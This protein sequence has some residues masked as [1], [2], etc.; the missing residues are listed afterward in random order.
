MTPRSLKHSY[1]IVLVI[2]ALL[3]VGAGLLWSSDVDEDLREGLPE[4]TMGEG[5][6]TSVTCRACHPAQYDAWHRSYHRTMTQ[7]ATPSTVLGMFDDIVLECGVGVHI[8]TQ[9]NL[10]VG[11]PDLSTPEGYEVELALGEDL[12]E[13][14]S[15]ELVK[16]T[17]W[18][19]APAAS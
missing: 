5:F 2:C 19:H 13:H 10:E 12:R 4:Q 8:S 3:V 17:R 9:A 15:E 7:A 14:P 18:R 6:T 1:R 16:A 11:E